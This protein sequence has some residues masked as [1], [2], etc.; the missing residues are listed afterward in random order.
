[1]SISYL[2]LRTR[3]YAILTWGITPFLLGVIAIVR[4]FF[5]CCKQRKVTSFISEKNLPARKNAATKS[6]RATPSAVGVAHCALVG[7]VGIVA[8]IE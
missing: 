2:L 1:M 6:K 3:L 5:H 7:A 4:N 8:Y